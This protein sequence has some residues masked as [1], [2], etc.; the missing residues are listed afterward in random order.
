MT[1]DVVITQCK[2]S[3]SWLPGLLKPAAD[4]S[5]MV[6]R[7]RVFVY[8]KCGPQEDPQAL[9]QSLEAIAP[10]GYFELRLHDLRNYAM[11]SIG[12]A[13]HLARFDDGGSDAVMFLQG[14]PFHHQ[15]PESL[16]AVLKTMTTG[17]YLN[18]GS[19]FIHLN[20]RRFLGSSHE[21]VYEL[22]EKMGFPEATTFGGYCC[23]Q[24]VV[25]RRA[26]FSAPRDEVGVPGDGDA[27]AGNSSQHEVTVEDLQQYRKEIQQQLSGSSELESVLAYVDGDFQA[28]SENKIPVVYPRSYHYEQARRLLNQEIPIK[29]SQDTSHDARP[30]IHTSALYEHMWHVLF[31]KQGYLPMRKNDASL[32]SIL[33]TEGRHPVFGN[34]PLRAVAAGVAVKSMFDFG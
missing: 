19:D 23:S 22:L 20:E 13:A 33:R 2:E 21:C 4:N 27:A 30:G 7:V 15:V 14:D 32:P 17:V 24:F 25:T 3:L 12:Y 6:R 5:E 11:E 34:L 29:C 8:R 1:L 26:I 31:N 9:F 16:S 28:L 18:M 10:P